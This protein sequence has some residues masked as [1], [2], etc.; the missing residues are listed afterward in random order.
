MDTNALI[1]LSM[2]LPFA[3]MI[4]NLV[5]RDRPNLRDGL[6]LA[7]AIGTFVTARR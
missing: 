3:A 5:F 6:T 4:T 1:A 7:A 2:A